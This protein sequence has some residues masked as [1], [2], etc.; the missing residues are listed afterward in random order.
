[1]LFVKSKCSLH[2]A[3]AAAAPAVPAAC[4]R[5]ECLS[6]RP[7]PSRVRMCVYVTLCATECSGL[8]A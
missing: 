4:V 5:I 8:S 1:M 2:A 7:A 6:R 3:P